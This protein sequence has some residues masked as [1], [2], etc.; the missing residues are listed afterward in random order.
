MRMTPVVSVTDLG[1]EFDGVWVLQN[2]DF[3][4]YP[5]EIHALVGENGAGKSTLIKILAGIHQPS[6]GQVYVEGHKVSLDNPKQSEELGIRTVH[7][8]INLIPFF[9]VAENIFLG[10]E[11][12]NGRFGIKTLNGKAMREG[13]RDVL[14]RLGITLDVNTPAHSLDASMER[15]VELG[16]VLIYSPKVIIFDE[17]TTSL[18]EHERKQ[19]L[20]VI[21]DLR[22]T[23]LGIVYVSHNLDEALAISDRIT[24]FRDGRKVDTLTRQEA[25]LQKIISLMVGAKGFQGCTTA[26][27][28]PV[29]EPCL[30]VNRLFSQKLRDVSFKLSRG[31]ILGI[32]GAV[33]AG[34]SEVG[35]AIFGLDA[36]RGEIK[37]FGNLYQPHPTRSVRQSIAFVPEERQKQGLFLNMP[38]RANLT[39]AHLDRWAKF[40]CID[41]EKEVELTSEYISKLHI[42]TTGHKQ[43][44]RFL[45]GGNQQKVILAR[46]LAGDFQV[47]IFDEPT[48]GV[49]LQTREEIY[50]IM[51]QLSNQGKS[52]LLLSSYVPEL[53]ATCHRILVMRNGAICGEFCPT[54][55]NVQEKIMAKMLGGEQSLEDSLAQS[56]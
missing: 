36:F 34:K 22:K 49:D 11:P 12:K 16:R 42:K 38:V 9:S 23:G 52:I 20:A 6:S 4:V 8:E 5:G 29:G 2:V 7:Q 25:T 21:S 55:D 10:H 56:H 3:N 24:V 30:E 1:K 33:G 18:G 13:A 39:I 35:N 53:I 48:R 50:S 47:G 26:R 51:H 46:W 14:R 31:E 27:S 44:I 41:H 15:V 28:M 19:L 32:A 17:P 40:G 45:S 54:E 43:L 37:V